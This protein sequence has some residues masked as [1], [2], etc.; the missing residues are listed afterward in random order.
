MANKNMVPIQAGQQ[1]MNPNA[2]PQN[3]NPNTINHP[4]NV[5]NVNL[6][7]NVNPNLMKQRISTPQTKGN[8]FFQN[9]IDV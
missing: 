4:Q 5:N 9:N 1:R 6:N 8:F 3:M 2:I 7:P